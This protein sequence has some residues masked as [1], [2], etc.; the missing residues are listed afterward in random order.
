[1]MKRDTL[2]DAF[3]AAPWYLK[4]LPPN[5]HAWTVPWAMLVDAEGH[6]YL[7]PMYTW[8]LAPAGTASMEIW[9]ADEGWHVCLA[10]C[11][12]YRWDRRPVSDDVLQHW[13][14][15]QHIHTEGR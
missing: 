1:M 6:G 7:N 8:H 2:P 10:Q 15:V 3:G 12:G 5:T 11:R 14:P 9:W 4:A 13:L